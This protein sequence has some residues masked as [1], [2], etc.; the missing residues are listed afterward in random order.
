MYIICKKRCNLGKIA[1]LLAHVEKYMQNEQIQ[2]AIKIQRVWKGHHCRQTMDQRKVLV[3]RYK[4][5]VILQRGVCY[6][7][8]VYKQKEQL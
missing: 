8:Y 4:A 2:A 7:I 6:D 1:F 5:A 3:R